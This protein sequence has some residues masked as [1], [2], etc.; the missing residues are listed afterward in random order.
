M[1]F[2]KRATKIF[3][4]LGIDAYWAD[5]WN[6]FDGGIVILSIIEIILKLSLGS[7][8]SG[9]SGLRTFRLLRVKYLVR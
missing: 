6:R 5:N 2:L 3:T 9:L 1:I 7:E 4:I 8:N